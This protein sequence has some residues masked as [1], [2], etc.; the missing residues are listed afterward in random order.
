MSSYSIKELLE[1][2]S[3]VYKVKLVQE[4]SFQSELTSGT[5]PSTIPI[6]K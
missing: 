3:D 5:T 1:S 4:K 2:V 6:S